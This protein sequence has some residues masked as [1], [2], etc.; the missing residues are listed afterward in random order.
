MYKSG[1]CNT[2]Q[3]ISERKQCRAN[4]PVSIVTLYGLSIVD[5]SG[6]LG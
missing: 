1:F 5:K 3:A 2:K 6:D 4:T